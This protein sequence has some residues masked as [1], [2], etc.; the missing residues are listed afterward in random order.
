MIKV[1]TYSW[2]HEQNCQS[3]KTYLLG[4]VPSESVLGGG[5]GRGRFHFGLGVEQVN[6]LLFEEAEMLKG[7]SL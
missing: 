2:I 6:R 1:L 7:D 3:N 4:G 5:G